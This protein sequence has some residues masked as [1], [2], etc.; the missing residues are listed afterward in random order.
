MFSQTTVGTDLQQQQQH[1]Q[2]TRSRTDC[3]PFN[4]AAGLNVSQHVRLGH[5]VGQKVGHNVGQ[6]V[7]HNVG[8]KVGQN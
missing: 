4:P 5:N 6:K 2:V 1:I 7:G 3:L 8:Q